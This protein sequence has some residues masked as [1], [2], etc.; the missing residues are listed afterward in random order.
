MSRIEE[1][2]TCAAVPPAPGGFLMNL[3]S[4]DFVARAECVGQRGEVIWLHVVSDAA[5]AL[6]YFAI[7]LALVALMRRRKDLEFGWMFAMFAAFILACGT[8]HVFNVLAFWWPMYRL[9]GLVKAGTGAV[10]IATAIALWP[11]IPRAVA[12]PSPSQL[13]SLNDR[14]EREV[15]VRREAEARLEGANAELEARVAA[16]TMELAE[17]KAQLEQRVAELEAVYRTEAVGLCKVDARLAVLRLND[18]LAA[19]LGVEAHAAAGRSLAE[20]AP[21][22]A[23]AVVDRSAVSTDSQVFT[24]A[25]DGE[26][27]PR[28]WYV[29]A[30]RLPLSGDTPPGHSLAV[31]DVSERARLE[32]QV[33]QSQ[34]MDAVGQLAGGVAHD[35]SNTLTAIYGYLSMARAALSPGDPVAD[36][37]DKLGIAADQASRI[38]KS[39]LSFARPEP[40]RREPV[41]VAAVLNR[42]LEI[43][44]GTMPANI[45][46]VAEVNATH[47]VWVRA[48]ATQIQQVVVNLALNARDAM[49]RGGKMAVAARCDER[50]VTIRVTDTGD[51][52]AP[53]HLGRIFEPFF[54]TKPRG[55]GTGLGLSVVHSIVRGHNGRIAVDSTP[56]VGT[57]ITVHLERV[58]PPARVNGGGSPAPIPVADGA[59]VIVAEDNAHVRDILAFQL[60][61]AGYRVLMTPDGEELLRTRRGAGEAAVLVLD[62]DMPRKSGLQALRELREAGDTIPAV[63]ITGG[64]VDGVTL[65]AATTLLLKPFGGTELLRA[66]SAALASRAAG[67]ATHE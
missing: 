31:L 15:G 52:I 10:S 35:I 8:T 62:V 18:A 26:E 11:L 55:V 13:R 5:I 25:P 30:S 54:T 34:K 29:S 46:V 50:E 28:R 63:L 59:T 40:A 27:N 32:A 9:D 36:L 60:R 67:A 2:A 43:V 49:P 39:L 57:T 17:S 3:F 20:L 16:R 66:I 4:T 41:E 42:A 45:D 14:L 23:R 19:M 61:R 65:D 12:L 37:L 51:G 48:D 38:T 64:P 6:A 22:L 1:C 58:A 53:E 47:G 24:L 33:A 7:P 44:R 21:E 56:G